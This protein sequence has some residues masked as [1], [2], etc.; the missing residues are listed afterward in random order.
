MDR[1]W[2]LM[3]GLI[4]LMGIFFNLAAGDQLA[5]SRAEGQGKLAYQLNQLCQHLKEDPVFRSSISLGTRAAPDYDEQSLLEKSR[6]IFGKDLIR[7]VF[8]K[9]PGVRVY[10][11]LGLGPLFLYQQ[12]EGG[13]LRRYR[14]GASICQE[15]RKKAEGTQV[16]YRLV[17]KPA[18]RR[19]LSRLEQ[20]LGL[21]PLSG[22][23]GVHLLL[24]EAGGRPGLSWHRVSLG[25]DQ[26]KN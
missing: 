23:L 3:L 7:A 12:E 14:R 1:I 2:G 15:L 25:Q 6:E 11:G 16:R 10:D 24:W 20:D 19:A 13:I 26:Y 4:F 21:E 17:D 9:G 22:Q 5:F 18:Y 8:I